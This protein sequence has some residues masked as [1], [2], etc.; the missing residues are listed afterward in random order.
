MHFLS[1]HQDSYCQ[2]DIYHSHRYHIQYFH[3]ILLQQLLFFGWEDFIH[4]MILN[5]I[6]FFLSVKFL[7]SCSIGLAVLSRPAFRILRTKVPQDSS[8]IWWT[9]GSMDE[10]CGFGAT[11]RMIYIHFSALASVLTPTEISI[12][13][14]GLS[15]HFL[16][17]NSTVDICPSVLL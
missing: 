10:T 12:W 16:T 15:C 14:G 4:C 1:Y 2:F 11:L 8:F 3:V 9:T 5:I 6:V 7:F 13:Q 17:V